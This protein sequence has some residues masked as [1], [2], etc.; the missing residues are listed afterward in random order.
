[1]D[2][3]E[4]Q[5]ATTLDGIRKDHRARYQW[6]APRLIGK[7]VVDIGCGVGYGA[8]I[9][10]EAGVEKVRA[11]DRDAEAIAFAQEHWAH[12]KIDYYQAD[13]PGVRHPS[14]QSYDAATAFE[15][16]EHLE[17]PLQ[18]LKAAHEMAPLLFASVP[19]EDAIPFNPTTCPYHVRHYT[20]EQFEDLLNKAG[21]EVLEWWGQLDAWSV[22]ERNRAG[23]TTIA[24][25]RA[26]DTL[27]LRK[28]GKGP[29]R[30]PKCS[31]FLS[32]SNECTEH[33]TWV[34]PLPRVATWVNIGPP[35]L[36]P[37][38]VA[39]VAMG[40]SK[41]TFINLAANLGDPWRIAD[42]IWA[43][44]SMGNLIRHDI[45]FHMDDLKVQEIRAAAQ[46]E[47][48]VAGMLRWLRTHDR[49]IMTCKAYDDYPMSQELPVDGC[50]NAVG[51]PYLNTTVSHAVAY[52]IYLGV[53]KISMYGADFSYPNVHKRERGRANVEFLLGIAAAR[54]IQ[55][56][57]AQDST[58]LDAV[59]PDYM[60]IYG[61]DMEDI[62]VFHNGH[63]WEMKRTVKATPPTA[64]EIENRY[65]HVFPKKEAA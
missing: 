50:L 57:V 51:Y 4:R 44:N 38:H 62:G 18:T 43:I 65:E 16:L 56:E 52:A 61:Y 37:D 39:I 10:A 48:N 64:E 28:D 11:F 34:G 30:C 23:R 29:R 47:S 15:V 5:I 20:P 6:V 13:A 2:P 60:R 3:R 42:Q 26:V 24:V 12:D 8:H 36:V 27:P 7:R 49:P 22:P 46:P 21:Y 32:R 53:K 59:E 25:A 19:N 9:L 58:L 35:P 14:L 17:D 55:I 33:G 41:Q 31:R 40:S 1:M 54:G 63:G 45:L